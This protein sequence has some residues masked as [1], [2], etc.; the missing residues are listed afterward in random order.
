LRQAGFWTAL[1]GRAVN[2]ANW[3]DLKDDALE[4][5][6]VERWRFR[7]AL[8]AVIFA[9]AVLTTYLGRD[10]LP[11]FAGRLAVSV[12]AGAALAAGAGALAMRGTDLRIHREL[13][14]RRLDAGTRQD[15]TG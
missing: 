6:L 11:T 1:E 15:P 13:R 7:G 9:A 2:H 5:L 8:L 10:G 4:K 14:R 12:L 3:R